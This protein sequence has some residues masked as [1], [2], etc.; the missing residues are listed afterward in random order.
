MSAATAQATVSCDNYDVQE[1]AQLILNDSNADA[2]DPDGDGVACEELP[3]SDSPFI[4]DSPFIDDEDKA[5]N[6][7][8]A[9]DSSSEQLTDEEQEYFDALDEGTQQIGDASGEIGS[10]FQEAADDPTVIFDEDWMISLATQ[11]FIWQEV[12]ERA[13]TLDP[14]PRQQPIHDLWLEINR[15]TTLAVD[16][17]II[18]IDELDSIAAATGSARVNY[19]AVLTDDLTAAINAFRDDPNSPVEPDGVIAPV[20]DCEAFDTFA[21]AQQYY[22][23]NPEEQSTIDPNFDGR[24]CEVFFGE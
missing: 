18:F 8:Q 6:A 12:G 10:L 1:I 2:L 17:Y 15:L 11:F 21:D 19:A 22:G 14:S 3:S 23:A 7:G 4:A 9:D 24:A 16:D 20:A 13:Q 5:R